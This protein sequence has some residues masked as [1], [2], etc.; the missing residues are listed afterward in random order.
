MFLVEAHLVLHDIPF[1]NTAV[2]G[3]QWDKHCTA[4]LPQ[5]LFP[6]FLCTVHAQNS[7]HPPPFFKISILGEILF[8]VKIVYIYVGP[9]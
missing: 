8:W 7:M 2:R 4:A 6:S 3:K 9:G 5:Q 1:N